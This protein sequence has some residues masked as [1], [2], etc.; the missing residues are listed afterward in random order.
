MK[1]RYIAATVGLTISLLYIIADLA[2]LLPPSKINALSEFGLR[3]LFVS[4]KG[5]TKAQW[6]Q[7]GRQSFSCFFENKEYGYYCGIDIRVGDGREH[8]E[9]LSKFT[10]L[11]LKLIFL[12]DGNQVRIN[13][14]NA[15]DDISVS[16]DGKQHDIPQPL[17]K[18][19]NDFFIPLDSFTIPH[20]W[21]NKHPDLDESYL[22]TQRDNVTHIGLFYEEPNVTGEHEFR[23]EE[24]VIVN[25]W[26]SLLR[27]IAYIMFPA[28]LLIAIAPPIIHRIRNRP[29]RSHPDSK[30]KGDIRIECEELLKRQTSELDI[31]EVTSGLL[32]QKITLTLL[33]SYAEKYSLSDIVILTISLNKYDQVETQFGIEAAKE[34]RLAASI[35]VKSSVNQQGVT[36]SWSESQF[37]VLLP[38][39]MA[40]HAK[41]IADDIRREARAGKF[42]QHN[43]ALDLSVRVTS[44]STLDDFST[45]FN[46]TAKQT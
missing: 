38:H 24:L 22:N 1:K 11:K 28:T 39:V 27:T 45:A 41:R 6:S 34:Y 18:G 5:K 46:H 23:I 3:S 33:K 4:D 16:P 14:R 7:H 40:P 36:C 20:Y 32:S 31:Y 17:K 30:P 26:Q 42:S 9:D 8:G 35:A 21:I 29:D 10:H 2:G 15:F 44:I 25:R 13:F 12:G 37:L 19:L 43:L